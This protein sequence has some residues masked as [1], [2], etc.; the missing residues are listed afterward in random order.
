MKT[1]GL[2]RAIIFLAPANT[3]NS[4]PHFF[5]QNYTKKCLHIKNIILYLKMNVFVCKNVILATFSVDFEE[6]DWTVEIHVIHRF[7]LDP[8]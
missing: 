1:Y 2:S 7:H 5:L 3:S 8:L 4:I 6:V